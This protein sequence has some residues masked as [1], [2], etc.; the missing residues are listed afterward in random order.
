M[1]LGVLS[2][3][4]ADVELD[5]DFAGQVILGSVKLLANLD[6]DSISNKFCLH[7]RHATVLS[8]T[9]NGASCNWS[10]RDLMTDVMVP[11]DG[12]YCDSISYTARLR[13]AV[14]RS[15]VGELEVFLPPSGI[16]R[17]GTSEIVLTYSRPLAPSHGLGQ[18]VS[19]DGRSYM[20]FTN[21]GTDMARCWV[22][23]GGGGAAGCTF[24]SP[25]G[26]RRS[27][28]GGG[29][30]PPPPPPPSTPLSPLCAQVPCVDSLWLHH[31][32]NVSISLPQGYS[33]I[34]GCDRLEARTDDS[35]GC[36]WDFTIHKAC[37]GGIGWAIGIFAHVHSQETLKV[38][39]SPHLAALSP[40]V[41]VGVSR[42]LHIARSFLLELV[43]VNEKVPRLPLLPSGLVSLLTFVQAEVRSRCSRGLFVAPLRASFSAP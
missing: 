15:V 31:E 29:P 42:S 30:P 22:G 9:I 13:E 11:Q 12:D 26:A 37:A 16:P 24:F 28:P 34:C 14:N 21:G 33:A 5:F 10:H 25:P 39:A 1:T 3:S 40:S 43:H 19:S 17:G 18:A 20:L 4:R 36:T 38:F 32:W 35:G 6:T 7:C 2:I 27:P 41:C 23:G 8:I